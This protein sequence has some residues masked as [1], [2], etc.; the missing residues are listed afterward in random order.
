[1]LGPHKRTIS[2]WSKKLS[3]KEV[4]IPIKFEFHIRKEE[5]L[6]VLSESRVPV[7][8]EVVGIN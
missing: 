4:T 5:L 8:L 7:S 2:I 6:A 3:F 1:M